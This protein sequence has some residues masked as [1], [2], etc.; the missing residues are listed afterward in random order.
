MFAN[1][2]VHEPKPPDDPDSALK[3][4][5]EGA[6][7]QPPPAL[8]PFFWSPGWNSIQSLNKFQEEVGGPLK[9]GV[10]GVRLIEPTGAPAE[11]ASPPPA[12]SPHPGEFRIVPLYDVF[13]SDE[14][15]RYAR[16]VSTLIP[17]PY[18]ALN[19]EDAAALHLAEGREITVCGGR[20]P[21]RLLPELPRGVAG[22]PVG[23][24][25]FLTPPPEWSAVTP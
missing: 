17:R 16:S 12:F 5:F 7:V 21:I 19:P 11:P 1:I 25:P 13:G 15:G 14:L 20:A 9:G 4:S 18:V 6:R 2:D 22:I 10:P 24:P 3:F 8:I 23:I